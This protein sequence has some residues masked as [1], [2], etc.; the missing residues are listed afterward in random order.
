MCRESQETNSRQGRAGGTK[1]GGQW[2]KE[3]S[4]GGGRRRGDVEDYWGGRG[5]GGGV[6]T[7][8]TGGIEGPAWVGPMRKTTMDTQFR[9]KGGAWQDK[10]APNTRRT[11]TSGGERGGRRV[12]G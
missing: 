12:A 9:R 7:H 1:D 8:K 11:R 3:G 10:I 5:W 4:S 2:E 6:V